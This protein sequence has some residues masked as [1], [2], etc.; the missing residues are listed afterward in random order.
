[1]RTSAPDTWKSET[2]SRTAR[3][4]SGAPSAS[5][6]APWTLPSTASILTSLLPEEHD[7]Q[8]ELDA[9][10]ELAVSETFTDGNLVSWVINDQGIYEREKVSIQREA[11]LKD[12]IA[13][14]ELRSPDE[15]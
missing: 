10:L 6:H 13:A 8:A 9:L 5:S 7:T 11:R 14:T 15:V 1:M 12:R 2:S 4:T 3:P